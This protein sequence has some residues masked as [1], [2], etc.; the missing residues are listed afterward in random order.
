MKTTMNYKSVVVIGAFNPSILTPD[1][2]SQR[3]DYQSDHVPEGRTTPVASEIKFGNVHFLTELS[4]F[5][6]TVK[7]LED[8]A[9]LFPVDIAEKYLDVLQYTPLNLFGV[10]FNYHLSE[11]DIP[12]VRNVF[13]DIWTIGQVIDADPTSVSYTARKPNGGQL[14]P[15]EV[16]L[17]HLVDTDLKNSIKITFEENAILVNINYEVGQL[18][19]DRS[20]VG[21]IH[22]RHEE[23]VG[24][25]QTLLSKLER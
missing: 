4:K 12:A 5:Q 10:N 25:C 19:T 18:E 1:F 14:I 9:G 3:C 23:L 17:V 16:T 21:I 2:L 11:I 6:I 20:K 7:D 24:R 15:Y 13:R 8:F 22:Q